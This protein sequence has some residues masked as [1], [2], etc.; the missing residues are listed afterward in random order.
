VTTYAD[1]DD[2]GLS[3]ERELHREATV[4]AVCHRCGAQSEPIP[5][6]ESGNPADPWTGVNIWAYL[7]LKGHEDDCPGR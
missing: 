4:T 7:A 5:L 3:E 1:Q 2:A 6:T